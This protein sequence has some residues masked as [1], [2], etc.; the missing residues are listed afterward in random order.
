MVIIRKQ[1]HFIAALRNIWSPPPSPSNQGLPGAFLQS[2]RTLFHILDDR[3]RGWCT[4]G[5]DARQLPRGV[6]QGLCQVAPASSDLIFERFVAGLRTSLLRLTAPRAP[7]APRPPRGPVAAAAPGVGAPLL[8]AVCTGEEAPAPGRA[9][10]PAVPSSAGP[11]PGA[12]VVPPSTPSR[13]RPAPRSPSSPR[14]RRWNRA[15]AR[16]QAL[17]ADSGDARRPR[18]RGERRRLTITCGV[19]CGLPKQVKELEQEEVLLQGLEMMA[20]GGDGYQ[21]QQQQERRLG[22]SRARADFGVA[23]SPHP[24]GRLLP[25]GTGGGPGPGG[26]AGCGLCQPDPAHSSSG[27]PCPA[28]TSTSPQAGS[29]RPSSCRRSRTDFSPRRWLRRDGDLWTPLSSSPCEAQRAPRAGLALSPGRAGAPSH[30]SSLSGD[31]RQAQ[32]QSLSGRLPAPLAIRAP[33]ACPRLTSRRALDSVFAPGADMGWDSLESAWPAATAADGKALLTPGCTS[34]NGQ[35]RAP[36]G[37]DAGPRPDFPLPRAPGQGGCRLDGSR[38]RGTPHAVLAFL[39]LART[40]P[41]VE[42]PHNN[43]FQEK[44]ATS[45]SQDNENPQGTG[46]GWGRSPWVSLP[47]P[48]PGPLL[49]CWGRYWWGAPAQPGLVVLSA[50]RARLHTHLPTATSQSYIPSCTQSA[51]VSQDR[52]KPAQRAAALLP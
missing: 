34:D 31:P 11:Q 28:P 14:A 33:Q 40:L 52:L 16:T 13:R 15:R 32:V 44:E 8:A 46:G 3:Q 37:C 7:S 1:R 36:G 47:A 22:Q 41:H 17:E 45:L 35:Q 10:S 39:I 26:A 42:F 19:D 2:Q 29:S 30:S 20:R 12:A 48:H 9:P 4:C 5:A 43:L 18:A 23:E 21:Q 24:L 49:V 6:L 25:R 51:G 27:P 38:W 50:T